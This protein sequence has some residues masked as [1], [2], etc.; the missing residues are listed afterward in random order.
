[1]RLPNLKGRLVNLRGFKR[2]D[3]ASIQGYANDPQVVRY[4]PRMPH[5]YGP[6]DARR[7]INFAQ[8]TARK[9]SAYFFGIEHAERRE[10]VGGI[11]LKQVFCQDQA[12][13]IGYWLARPF[14]GK[15]IAT[16]AVRLILE[17]SFETLKLHRVFAVTHQENVGSSRVLEKNG[18][19]REGTFRKSAKIGD[20]WQDLYSYGILRSE[21]EQH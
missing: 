14:W 10:V 7:W 2:S 19:M 11:G 9:D 6:E 17:F 4:L 5:P 3:A 16:E 18:F 21:F 8:L 13:E 1:M 15:S 20:H 12:T